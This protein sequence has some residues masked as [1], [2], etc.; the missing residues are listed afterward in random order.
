MDLL[1]EML[2]EIQGYNFRF[3]SKRFQWEGARFSARIKGLFLN[4]SKIK[5][6]N[7]KF[8]IQS[9]IDGKPLGDRITNT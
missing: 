9:I 4:I 2:L 6:L 1:L 8:V 3:N 5:L 7:H